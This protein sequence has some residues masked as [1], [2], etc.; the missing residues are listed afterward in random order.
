MK[1]LFALLMAGVFAVVLAGGTGGISGVV[2]D[3]V[4]GNPIIG[5][6]VCAMH[7]GCA[8]TNENGAY[9]IENLRPGDYRVTASAS[10]YRCKT[11]PEMVTVV[12][13]QVTENINFA[14]APFTPPQPGGISG[15]VTD[16]ATGNP[17]VGARVHAMGGHR[18]C[19]SATT[20][21]NGEYLIQNLPAGSYRVTAGA[22]GYTPKTYPEPVSVV[23]GQI[24]PNINFALTPFIPPTPGSISGTVT[25]K[26][27][28]EPIAGAVVMAARMRRG[29]HPGRGFARALT[30]PDGTYT[31]ENLLPGEYRVMAHALGFKRQVYPELVVVQEG[32]NT[33]NI[34][35][36]LLPISINQGQTLEKIKIRPATRK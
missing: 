3:S 24:T 23:E 35:F 33:P 28:G 11:Y 14:L 1:S 27:T 21:E 7:G 25:D 8:T 17:I 10:G 6:R 12:A 34:N 19:G 9:L 18:I 22:Q 2:T 16:S 13:G 20:N 32:Q 36:E 30:G 29:H 4:T 26:N 15:V 31:I 5:A